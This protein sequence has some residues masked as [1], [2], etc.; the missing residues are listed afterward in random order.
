MKNYQILLVSI[1]S[2][3]VA[4]SI[5]AGIAQQYVY[6]AGPDN[7]MGCFVISGSMGI[8]SLMSVDY[9]KLIKGLN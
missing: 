5:M 2:F 3:G 7:E 8:L 4:Y 6:F 1:L 9:K